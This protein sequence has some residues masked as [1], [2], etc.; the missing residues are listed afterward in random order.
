MLDDFKTFVMRGNVVDL[1]VGVIIGAAFGAI[2]K[3]LVDDVIMPPIGLLLGGL[4]FTNM[5]VV[6][7][8]GT[9]AAG[10][11]ATLA[12]AKEA[13]AV[14]LNYGLFITSIVTFVII[15]FAVYLLVKA[16]NR[17]H[18]PAAA[19]ATTKDCP[20]CAMAIPL[21]ARKCPHCTTVL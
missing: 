14:T 19:P 5:Y 11:Y 15:A 12:E 1:A 21:L 7:K 8:E 10:P 18:R 3:S 20:E 17:M 16:V 13:G 2:T 9:T 6:L 4:D